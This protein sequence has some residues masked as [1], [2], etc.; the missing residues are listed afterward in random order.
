MSR[1]STKQRRSA[2]RRR[3]AVALAEVESGFR[4]FYYWHARLFSIAPSWKG[5]LVARVDEMGDKP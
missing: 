2:K 4:P 1:L 3:H 5:K